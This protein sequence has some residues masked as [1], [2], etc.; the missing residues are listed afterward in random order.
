MYG[1]TLLDT[2]LGGEAEVL[3]GGADGELPEENAEAEEPESEV[4]LPDYAESRQA[5]RRNYG[6]AG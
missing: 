4:V 2:I 3:L 6:V 5:H 1:W